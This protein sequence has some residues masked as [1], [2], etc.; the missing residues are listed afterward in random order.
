MA[1]GHG[2]AHESPDLRHES[3]QESAQRRASRAKKLLERRGW[4]AQRNNLQ[5]ARRE[6]ASIAEHRDVQCLKKISRRAESQLF[7]RVAGVAQLAGGKHDSDYRE[8]MF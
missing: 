3:G 2:S 5:Q 6:N 1:K 4:H 8:L 7:W